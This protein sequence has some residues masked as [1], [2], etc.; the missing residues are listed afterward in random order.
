MKENLDDAITNI[1]LIENDKL[2]SKEVKRILGVID[3]YEMDAYQLYY[4]KGYLWNI[5]PFDTS[6]RNAKTIEFLSKSIEIKSDYIFSKT[7]LSF[8]YFDQ[9]EYAKVLELLEGLDVSFFEEKGQLW[10]SLKLQELCFVSKLYESKIVTEE[11]VADFLYI[12]S[13]YIYL[14]DEE[15]SVPREL[16]NA[17]SENK[18]KEGVFPILH[19]VLQLVNSK[20]QRDYFDDTIK[21]ELKECLE[22]KDFL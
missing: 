8:Y 18:E 3:S 15:V 16:V 1:E 6:E 5:Y 12:V 11:L 20:K 13:A 17:M 10:K 14:P 7:E 2:R 9:K 22:A 19:N 4:L 21:Q